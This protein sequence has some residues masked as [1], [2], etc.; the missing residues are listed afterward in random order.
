MVVDTGFDGPIR[1]RIPNLAIGA[2]GIPLKISLEG[3]ACA[4]SSDFAR[5]APILWPKRSG[6]TVAKN[7]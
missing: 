4:V 7:L 1:V 3:L 6:S 2:T 5:R